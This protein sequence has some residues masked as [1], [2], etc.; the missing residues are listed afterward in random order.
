MFGN[1]YPFITTLLWMF[2]LRCSWIIHK[3]LLICL[4]GSLLAES[5]AAYRVKIPGLEVLQHQ[6]DVLMADFYT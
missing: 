5:L 2:Q 4:W 6:I 1:E 3:T